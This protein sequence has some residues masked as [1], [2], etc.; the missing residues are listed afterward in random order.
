MATIQSGWTLPAGSRNNQA[1]DGFLA[2]LK[3]GFEIINNP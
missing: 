2:T 3:T 1:R